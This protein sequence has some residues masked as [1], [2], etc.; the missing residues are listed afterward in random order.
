MACSLVSHGIVL[1]SVIG[2]GTEQN[3]SCCGHNNTKRDKGFATSF[4][5]FMVKFL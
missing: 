5:I 1:K 4:I 2:R 3:E